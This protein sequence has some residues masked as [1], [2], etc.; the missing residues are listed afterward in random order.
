MAIPYNYLNAGVWNVQGLFTVINK[1]KL[2]KLVEPVV[3]KRIKTFDILAL[4]EIQCGPS[5]T[6]GLS[7]HGF[8]LLP[9]HRTMSSNNR[10]F[11]GMHLLIR[12][13]IRKGIRIID[14]VNS[15]KI[16]IKLDK[17]FS[18]LRKTYILVSF[19]HPLARHHT[20]RT[21]IMTYFKISRK[22]FPNTR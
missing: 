13:N 3:L 1:V 5:D 9:F 8:C 10:F 4:Q 11:G 18:T 20:Q 2:C 19:M 14:N 16:W 21:L 17:T 12:K 6:Q 22:I 15:D 7:V